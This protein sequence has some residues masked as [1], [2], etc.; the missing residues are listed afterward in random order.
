[1]TQEYARAAVADISYDIVMKLDFEQR[2]VGSQIRVVAPRLPLAQIRLP[3]N[4]WPRSVK[5]PRS[6]IRKEV[7]RPYRAT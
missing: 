4:C 6:A 7:P 3:K 1:M 5:F 2:V